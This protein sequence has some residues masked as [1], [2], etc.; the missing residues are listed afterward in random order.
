MEEGTDANEINHD[1]EELDLTSSHLPDLAG[2]EFPAGLRG[3][4]LTTNRLRELDTKILAL[5]GLKTLSLR[6]NILSDVS[7]LKDAAF[8][9]VLVE[10]ILQDNH[11]EE[12]PPLQGFTSLQ[13]LELSYNQIQSLLPLQRLDSTALCEL[14]VANN[15]VT[16]IEAVQQFTN[17]RLLELGSNKIREL[18]GL[19]ALTGLEE[20]WLGRNRIAHISGI[21]SLGMLRKLSLQSN[22][23]TSMAGLQHCPLLEELYLSHNGIQRLENLES[24]PILRVL[25]VSSNRV[26]DITGVEALTQL[27]DL[28]LNDNAIGSLADLAAAAGGPP[29]G[30]MT[31]LYLAGNPA[32]DEAGGHAA[33]RAAVLKLFPKLE[34][35][36]DEVL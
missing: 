33:Y 10:L 19:D 35:L 9:T 13:R 21:T 2:V 26:A 32:V 3:L 18:T 27:T 22:R 15:A 34:Q 8:K 4:D 17:L 11:I 36:D 5:T 14:Y 20:L 1:L 12:I 25:D 23:L 7:R 29:G 30:T 31:T 24:L 6:Q 16:A 28:W